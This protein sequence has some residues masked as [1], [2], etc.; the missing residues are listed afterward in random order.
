MLAS[1]GISDRRAR[2]Q[3]KHGEQAGARALLI[4]N[5]TDDYFVMSDDGSGNTVGIYAFL[6]SWSDG[7]MMKRHIQCTPPGGKE[8]EGGAG[9][10]AEFCRKGGVTVEYGLGFNTRK[11]HDMF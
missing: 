8:K 1:N 4:I 9:V 6:I 11:M 2:W 10:E 5:D 7:D 3:T